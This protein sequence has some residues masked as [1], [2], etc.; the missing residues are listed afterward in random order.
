MHVPVLTACSLCFVYFTDFA[1]FRPV[2]SLACQYI[3]LAVLSVVVAQLILIDGH[4]F[5]NVLI[6]I[7][8][9]LEFMASLVA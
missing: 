5:G 6:K 4:Y 8:S 2:C 1:N 7:T 3:M 9:S